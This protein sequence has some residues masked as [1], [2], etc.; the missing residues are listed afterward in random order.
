MAISLFEKWSVHSWHNADPSEALLWRE[1]KS[2]GSPTLTILLYCNTPCSQSPFLLLLY[3]GY[4]LLLIQISF[5]YLMHCISQPSKMLDPEHSW[6]TSMP[7]KKT[8][9]RPRIQWFCKNTLWVI[10]FQKTVTNDV[11]MHAKIKFMETNSTV[12][13]EGYYVNI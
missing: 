10:I 1:T 4:L 8:N 9:P 5:C 12:T 7:L 11:F 3:S 6:T 2:W 13:K